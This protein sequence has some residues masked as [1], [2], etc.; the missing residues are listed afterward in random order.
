MDGLP[1]SSDLCQPGVGLRPAV[2]EELPCVAHLPDHAEV[3]AVD[4]QLV[5]VAAGNRLDLSARVDEIALAVEFPDV[6]GGFP[7][8]AIDGAAIDAIG[9]GGGGL[10]ELPQIFRQT[11]DGCRRVDD[12]FRAIQRERPPTFGKCRS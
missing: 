1:L 11:G 5:L 7:A 6:P 2:A 12:I 4:E 9:D 8:H 3:H 10:L